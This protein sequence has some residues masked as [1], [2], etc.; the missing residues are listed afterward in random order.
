MYH[1]YIDTEHKL[2][3]AKGRKNGRTGKKCTGGQGA[4]TSSYK[5]NTS[6]EVTNS[7][8]KVVTNTVITL[9]GN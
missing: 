1:R 5:I 3:V 4:Q 6:R 8:E 9:Y 2:V 7:I